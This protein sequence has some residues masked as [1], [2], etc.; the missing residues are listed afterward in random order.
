MRLWTSAPSPTQSPILGSLHVGAEDVFGVDQRTPR[1]RSSAPTGAI[2]T[3][4]QMSC[5]GGMKPQACVPRLSCH[6]LVNG[7]SPSWGPAGPRWGFSMTR[8]PLPPLRVLLE[9]GLPR[10]AAFTA[11]SWHLSLLPMSRVIRLV[12]A[13]F[14]VVSALPESGPC[15]VCMACSGWDCDLTYLP[16]ST[17]RSPVVLPES[18]SQVEVRM[19]GTLQSPSHGSRGHSKGEEP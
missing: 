18:I 6:S 11:P 5:E 7:M 10:V 14:Q 1:P 3:L 15:L 19:T 2:C 9:P 8:N 17:F 12:S 16:R 13:Y 4:T